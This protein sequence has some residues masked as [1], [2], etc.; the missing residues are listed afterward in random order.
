MTWQVA[1]KPFMCNISYTIP[2]EFIKANTMMYSIESFWKS[3]TIPAARFF[4]YLK[5][6][7]YS[8]WKQPYPYMSNG[9]YEIQTEI[10]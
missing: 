2:I 8:Q 3:S 9:Y 5:H 4:Y 6:P 1:F 10:C 7:L